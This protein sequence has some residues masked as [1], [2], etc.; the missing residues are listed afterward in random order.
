MAEKKILMAACNFWDS[1]FQVGSH[2]IAKAFVQNGWKVAFISDPI[3][4]LHFLKK[5]NSEI[6]GRIKLNKSGGEWKLENQLW[7]Y[8]PFSLI[9]PYNK[10]IFN[11]EWV[12]ENW[13]KLTIPSVKNKLEEAGFGSVDLIYIDSIYQSFWLDNIDHKKSFFRIADNNSGFSRFN[14]AMEKV[15]KEIVAKSDLTI[16]SARNLESVADHLKPK[17]KL[18]VPNGVN[19]SHFLLGKKEIPE[20]LQNI[21]R[22]IAIYVGAISHWFDFDLVNTAALKLPHVSFVVIGNKELA[23]KKLEKRPNVFFLGTKKYAEIPQFL[24]HSDVGIIPFNL[25]DYPELVNSI[26]PL[27]L[28]EYMACGLQVVSVE[29]EE[30]KNINSPAYLAKTYVEFISGIEEAVNQK[31][32]NSEIMIEY[33]KS[34]DWKTRVKYLIEELEKKI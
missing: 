25:K 28:Y 32:S 8:V 3:S 24:Y 29:W 27:K 7:T 9:T 2:N 17:R 22:P 10:P 31:G 4:P 21:P 16:Y 6:D 19:F 34:Q 18:F 5:E 12:L 13:Y 1:P 15:E 20:E 30:L 11:S 26:N 33:A 23:E 14:S